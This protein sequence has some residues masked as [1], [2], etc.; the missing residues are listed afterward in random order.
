MRYVVAAC[1]VF[2]L[3]ALRCFWVLIRMMGDYSPDAVPTKKL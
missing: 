2:G 3:F 1:V